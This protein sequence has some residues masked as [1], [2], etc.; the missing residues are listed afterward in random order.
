MFHEMLHK[1]RKF[2]VRGTKTRYHDRKFRNAE[3][4]YENSKSIEKELNRFVSG[5]RIRSFFGLR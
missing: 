1:Q 5:V 4:I 2:E 3:K